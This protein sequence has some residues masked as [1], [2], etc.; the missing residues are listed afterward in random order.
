MQSAYRRKVLFAGV[1]LAVVGSVSWAVA[2]GPT[3]F[4]RRVDENGNGMID[5]S[6]MEGRM[7]SFIRR[8]AENNP[9]IDLSRPIPIDRLS[10]EFDRMREERMRS[11]A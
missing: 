6:E 5:P 3:D 2:Q 4:L 7:G 9:R 8:M 11:G 10:S 1:W